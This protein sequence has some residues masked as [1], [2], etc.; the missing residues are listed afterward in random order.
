MGTKIS[1]S[2]FHLL[3]L[4]QL[5]GLKGISCWE[6]NEFM[7]DWYTHTPNTIGWQCHAVYRRWLWGYRLTQRKRPAS[8]PHS[9][10]PSCKSVW[11]DEGSECCLLCTSSPR[12]VAQG[13][14]HSFREA[15]YEAVMLPPVTSSIMGARGF[16]T[17]CVTIKFHLHF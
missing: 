11:E 7:Q 14:S 1:L 5:T 15:L 3:R 2:K 4:L 8:S 17:N 6:M 12:P 10:H 16:D 9:S 13:P